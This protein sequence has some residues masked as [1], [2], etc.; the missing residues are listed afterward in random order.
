MSGTHLYFAGQEKKKFSLEALNSIDSTYF[1]SPTR[2]PF[3][4]ENLSPFCGW[5]S[6]NVFYLFV[7]LER[8]LTQNYD[9]PREWLRD[10]MIYTGLYADKYVFVLLMAPKS[11]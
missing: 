3:C 2:C 5:L 6:K 4:E 10:K 9:T 7:C 11:T 1:S 8:F